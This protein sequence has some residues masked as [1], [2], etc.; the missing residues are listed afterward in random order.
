[1]GIY[2]DDIIVEDEACRSRDNSSLEDHTFEYASSD[3]TYMCD[4]I[5]L[6]QEVKFLPTKPIDLLH[7]D[8]T[9]SPTRVTVQED[10]VCGGQSR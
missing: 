8:A 4:G 6:E 9:C 1:M 2:R 7:G 3:R 10:I 5:S